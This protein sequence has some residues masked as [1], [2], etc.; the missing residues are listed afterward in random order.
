MRWDFFKKKGEKTVDTVYFVFGS[1]LFSYGIEKIKNG[2]WAVTEALVDS[3]FIK[4]KIANNPLW[5]LI[6]LFFIIIAVALF[7]IP[8]WNI[9]L[10]AMTCTASFLCSWILYELRNYTRFNFFGFNKTVLCFAFFLLGM[11]FNKIKIFDRPVI[12]STAL[13]PLMLLQM[14]SKILHS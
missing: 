8:R 1:K 4:G 9:W 13:V 14:S 11:I 10:M 7:R 2:D 5:F 6:V 3:L 12:L